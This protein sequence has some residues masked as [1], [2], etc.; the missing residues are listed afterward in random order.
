MG[1]KGCVYIAFKYKDLSILFINSHMAC[2]C[3]LN[4][5]AGQSKSADRNSDFARINRDIISQGYEESDILER[6]ENHHT[7]T[8]KSK[9]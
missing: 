7:E 1:N 3:L 6:I 4:V 2:I 8:V 9:F 5:I